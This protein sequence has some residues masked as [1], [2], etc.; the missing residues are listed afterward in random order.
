LKC[1]NNNKEEY[2]KVING[3]ALVLNSNEDI[4]LLMYKKEEIAIYNK[5]DNVYIC[6]TMLKINA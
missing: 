3:N 4:I 2:E 1:I 5:D 6:N